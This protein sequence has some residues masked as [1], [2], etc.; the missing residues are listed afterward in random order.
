MHRVKWKRCKDAPEGVSRFEGCVILLKKRTEFF[1]TLG[2]SGNFREFL[3][4]F[5]KT[6]G[7]LLKAYEI[8]DSERFAKF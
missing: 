2:F 5:L 4:F 6:K 3:R 8:L 7:L 1:K